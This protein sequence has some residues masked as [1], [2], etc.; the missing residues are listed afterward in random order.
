MYECKGVKKGYISNLNR[1]IIKKYGK[2]TEQLLK[3]EANKNIVF[4]DEMLDS[5]GITD[6]YIRYFHKIYLNK[7]KKSRYYRK[8]SKKYPKDIQLKE[9]RFYYES[10]AG[11]YRTQLKTLYMEVLDNIDEGSVLYNS[12]GDY[13]WATGRPYFWLTPEACN[14]TKYPAVAES[15]AETF[16]KISFSR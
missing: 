7:L 15:V 11:F 1:E 14:L 9:R 3:T 2:L 13:Y 8:L 10:E 4:T 5:L 16:S 12:L 6:D